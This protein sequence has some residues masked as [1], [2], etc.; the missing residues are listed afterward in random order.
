MNKMNHKKVSEYGRIFFMFI[1]SVFLSSCLNWIMEKPSFVLREV[2]LNPHSLTDMNLLLG[3]E[4][5]NPNRFDLTLKSFEYSIY[6][7][8]EAIGNGLLEKEFLI[9]SSSTTRMQ[10]PVV[11]KFKDLAGSLKTIIAGNDI[12]YKIEG[13]TCVKTNFGSFNFLISKEGHINI[14]K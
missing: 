4:V 10:L 6:F 1:L 13:K 12:V 5:Q 3:I 14:R 2:I 11:A 8:N 9:P 7:N